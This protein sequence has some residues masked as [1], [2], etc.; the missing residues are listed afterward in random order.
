M[1]VSNVAWVKHP[2]GAH[3]D[4]MDGRVKPAPG[5]TAEGATRAREHRPHDRSDKSGACRSVLA[6]TTAAHLQPFRRRSN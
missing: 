6:F 3:H 1:V 2:V 4:S 5:T